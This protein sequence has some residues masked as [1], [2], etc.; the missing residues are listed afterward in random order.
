M[1]V[2][3]A[4]GISL[5]LAAMKGVPTLPKNEVFV[6]GMKNFD[7]KEECVHDRTGDIGITGMEESISIQK[8]EVMKN[9]QLCRQ[10]RNLCE[11]W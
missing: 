8:H 2:W 10:M 9:A 4:M 11:A 5:N 7:E 6:G 1:S 3:T